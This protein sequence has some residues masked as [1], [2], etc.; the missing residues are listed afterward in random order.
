MEIPVE[1]RRSTRRR[2]TVE[3]RLVDGTLRVAIPA[4]MTEAE[5][6]HWVEVMRRRI[7]RRSTTEEIDLEARARHLAGRFGLP[8][9]SSIVWSRRQ[10]TRWG[11]CSVDSGR[12]RISDRLAGFPEWVIDYVIVHELAH[13]LESGHNSR[14]W[15]I[16]NRY[17][18]A[19]RA[20]G[21]LLA[22]AESGD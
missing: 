8:A 17:P 14:F 15:K 6:T 9:P 13:L 12:V 11:S 20:R 7:A 4:T 16:V 1:V 18:L 2:K 22:R 10:T 5:E 19:E 21:Y 3:A